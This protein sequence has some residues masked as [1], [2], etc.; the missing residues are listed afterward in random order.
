MPITIRKATV[1]DAPAIATGESET[2]R[3]RGL[4]NAGPGEIPEPAFRRKIERLQHGDRGLYVVAES[5]DQIV[6]HLLLDPMPLAANAHICTLTLV[7]YSGWKSQGIGKQLLAHAI[8][9]ARQ[10]PRIEKIELMARTSNARA[11]S[12]YRSMGFEQEGLIRKRLKEAGGVY[13]DDIA[14]ALFV[15]SQD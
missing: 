6:G 14:M 9:W 11:I 8:A 3:T 4:L 12:L 13:H 15:V 7:V 1:E 2:A 5:E 10:N